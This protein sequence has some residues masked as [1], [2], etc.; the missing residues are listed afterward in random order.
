M[1]ETVVLCIT[2]AEKSHVYEVHDA[3]AQAAPV[4]ATRRSTTE[5]LHL[6]IYPD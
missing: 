3:G 1:T 6:W 4:A 2:S 5:A